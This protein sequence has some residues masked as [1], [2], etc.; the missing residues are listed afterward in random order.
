MRTAGCCRMSPLLSLSSPLP[1]CRTATNANIHACVSPQQPKYQPSTSH[2]RLQNSGFNIQ[3]VRFLVPTPG[4]HL[5]LVRSPTSRFSSWSSS[6]GR[7]QKLSRER[8]REGVGDAAT[9]TVFYLQWEFCETWPSQS[10]P[11]LNPNWERTQPLIP[12]EASLIHGW[13]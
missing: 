4:D 8:E 7:S 9:F 2:S 6:S 1:H 3:N 12:V 10:P 13:I 11:R 5:R